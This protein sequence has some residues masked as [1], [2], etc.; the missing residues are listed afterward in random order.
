MEKDRENFI[1]KIIIGVLVVIICF[2]VC[3]IVTNKGKNASINTLNNNQTIDDES[4]SYDDGYVLDDE[5]I[6]NEI[7]SIMEKYYNSYDFGNECGK[8]DYTDIYHPNGDSNSPD[9][10]RCLDYN[11]INDLKQYYNSF[12][13]ESFYSKM[14]DLNLIENDGKLYYL[15]SHAPAY[16][17][18]EGSLYIQVMKKDGSAINAIGI[19]KTVDGDSNPKYSFTAKMRFVY[20]DNHLVLYKYA[21]LVRNN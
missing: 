4:F 6:K 2:L 1:L 18:E 5:N 15:S 10:V 12:L 3:Y 9:Y 7:K 8:K 19:F 17:Y 14:F 21:H 13:S 20:N 16:T 11:S